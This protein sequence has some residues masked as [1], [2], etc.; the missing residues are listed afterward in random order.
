LGQ[1]IDCGNAGACLRRFA[2]EHRTRV[3]AAWSNEPIA[4]Q[5]RQ[6]AAWGIVRAAA[7]RFEACNRASAIDDQ[8]RRTGPQAVDQGAEVFLASVMLTVFIRLE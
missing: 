2:A 6:P 5:P 1:R 3:V 7:D 4:Q 8:H